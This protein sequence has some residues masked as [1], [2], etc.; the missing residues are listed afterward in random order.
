M[1]IGILGGTFDPPHVGH[2]LAASDAH[3]ELKLD[4]VLFIPAAQQPLKA[5]LSN[6]PV[7]TQPERAPAADRLQMVRLAIADDE[8]FEVSAI[9]INRGGLS[10]TVETL[11][12]LAESSPGDSWYFLIGADVLETFAKWREPERIL[13][14]AT[15]AVFTRG[16]GDGDSAKALWDRF[17]AEWRASHGRTPEHAP[18]FVNGRRVDVSSTEVRGRVTAGRSIHGFVPDAVAIYIAERGLYR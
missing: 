12:K 5:H 16:I 14:L 2:L 11:G 8:R 13:Q 9:E 1:R 15:L 10:Y 7:S 6:G 3:D 18:A 4:R 17:C